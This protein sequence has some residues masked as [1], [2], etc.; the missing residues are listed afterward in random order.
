MEEFNNSELVNSP[1][2]IVHIIYSVGLTI[3]VC[4]FIEFIR[5]EMFEKNVFKYLDKK[6]DSIEKKI[7]KK[8]DKRLSNK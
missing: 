4:L 6:I 1:L 8:I 5:K 2:L 7:F 3:I